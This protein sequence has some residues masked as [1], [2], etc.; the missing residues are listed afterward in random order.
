MPAMPWLEGR[1]AG[2]HRLV[3]QLGQRYRAGRPEFSATPRVIM[4]VCA[5]SARHYTSRADEEAYG[6]SPHDS[7]TQVRLMG[8]I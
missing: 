3:A 6:I 5:S 8:E 4:L 1:H 2:I 7:T